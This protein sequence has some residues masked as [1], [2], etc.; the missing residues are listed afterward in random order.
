L[1]GGLGAGEAVSSS[2]IASE[3]FFPE[4]AGI[5]FLEIPKSVLRRRYIAFLLSKTPETA[6][7]PLVE[8]MGIFLF[9][10]ENTL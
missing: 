6:V 10:D 1:S 3:I 8:T 5:S 2:S 7:N 4:N 9:F